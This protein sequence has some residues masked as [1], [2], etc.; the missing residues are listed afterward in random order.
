MAVSVMSARDARAGALC[1]Q[2]EQEEANDRLGALCLQLRWICYVISAAQRSERACRAP[3]TPRL[4]ATL[5][6]EY[7]IRV[8]LEPTLASPTS[9]R[10][11]NGP[12]R[13]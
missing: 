8:A 9:V 6:R 13:I 1:L 12:K 3:H 11:V 5:L 2:L 7:R 10:E 4:L